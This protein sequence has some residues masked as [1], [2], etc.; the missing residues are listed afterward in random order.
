MTHYYCS[1]FSK[2]YAYRGLL[3][4]NSLLRWDKDFHFFMVCL[5]DEVKKLFEQMNLKNAT[6]ISMSAVESEDPQLPAV[7]EMRNEQEY[8]W[9]SKASVML[10][11]LS[12]FEHI[13]HIVWLDGDTLFFS[14]PEPIFEEWGQHSIM[15]N[16]GRW[17]KAEQ[18]NIERY[19]RYNTGLM[20]FRRDKQALGCLNWFRDRL[21]EWCYAREE[22]KLWSDQVYVNDWPERFSSVTVVKNIGIN[23]TPP[24]IVDNKVT[25]DGKYIY[26]N[27]KRLVFF[28]YSQFTYYDGNE[29][30]LCRFVQYLSDDVLKMIYLPYIKACNEIMEQIRKVDRDFYLTARPKEKYIRNYF[31]LATNENAKK[32][33]NFCTVLSKDYLIQCLA[34]YN[35]L[36]KHTKQFHL[37]ILCVNDTTYSLLEKLN[38]DGVTLVSLKIIRDK[39]LAKIEKERQLNEFC[40]TLKASFIYYL[41]KNNYNLDSILYLDADLYF[42][43]DARDIYNEWGEHSVFLTRLW[44]SKKWEQRLG[45]YSAGLVG[46]KRDRNGLRCL[47]YW[48][49]QCLNWCYKRFQKGLWGD[50]KYLNEWPQ[51]FSKVKISKN[52]GVNAGSWNI[53]IGIRVKK[54][55]DVLYFNDTKLVCFHYSG[56]QII[57]ENKF[58]LCRWNKRA[59]RADNIYSVYVKEIRQII[60]Q[61]KSV[62][63]NFI[64]SLERKHRL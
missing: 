14:D 63:S 42:F 19:G 46:F 18:R 15:L 7:K 34:L 53:R 33:L 29:F 16:K 39:K 62:D 3:L 6:I 54:E 57:K 11:I 27:G 55:N 48:R 59:A 50:Q 21:I 58:E 49:K 22:K 30:E 44:Q 43:K 26:I 1:T 8:A 31:N 25:G 13:D 12:N 41:L 17:N 28:H 23:V 4:Y 9:T 47:K 52:K 10:H 61:V 38:L 36:K 2:G 45:R 60:A 64:S 20:G 56:F 32:M 40:W 37:W 5:N 24:V 51:K 35:S